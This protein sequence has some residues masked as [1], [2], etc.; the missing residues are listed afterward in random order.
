MAK[1]LYLEDISP[2]P[3]LSKGRKKESEPLKSIKESYKK[4]GAPMRVALTLIIIVLF[5]SLRV[6]LVSLCD[7]IFK[8]LAVNGMY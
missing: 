5:I 1:V 7:I 4:Y 6:M 3:T 8:S 2:F